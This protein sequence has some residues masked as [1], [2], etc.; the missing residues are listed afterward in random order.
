MDS[1]LWLPGTR[2]IPNES[3]ALAAENDDGHAGRGRGRD[4]DGGHDGRP[5]A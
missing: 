2:A 3:R 5:A 4:R 1:A